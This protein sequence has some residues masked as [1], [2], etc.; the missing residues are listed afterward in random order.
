M[1]YAGHTVTFRGRSAGGARAS[2]LLQAD[3][4]GHWTLLVASPVRGAGY[5]LR[6]N[7]PV[8]GM[9]SAPSG[10]MR[11]RASLRRASRTLAVSPVVSLDITQ[12]Q[13]QLVSSFAL[14]PLLGHGRMVLIRYLRLGANAADDS[15]FAAGAATNA[16]NGI[17]T[18]AV[19]CADAQ[20]AA[21]TLARAYVYAPVTVDN[22]P[23]CKQVMNAQFDGVAGSAGG[24]ER[25]YLPSGRP[26]ASETNAAFTLQ[27]FNLEPDR[28]ANAVVKGWMNVPYMTVLT[29]EI[30]GNDDLD[31][32]AASNIIDSP[33]P[34]TASVD[35]VIQSFEPWCPACISSEAE[36]HL[37]EWADA[38]PALRIVAFACDGNSTQASDWGYEHGWRF[39]VILYNGQLSIGDCFDK[40]DKPLGITWNS[41]TVFYESGYGSEEDDACEFPDVPTYGGYTGCNP[42][43]WSQ[44]APDES[45]TYLED[46]YNEWWNEGGR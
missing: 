21:F 40:V 10:A 42:G 35:E 37:Q 24:P 39:P 3:T 36:Y 17:D 5:H 11:I 18:V 43:T 13:P 45:A 7:V 23:G 20:T 8:T 12:P 4:A 30:Q 25:L 16:S 34:V 31:V 1:A 19:I 15:E 6:W 33:T 14:A 2:V 46:L 44:S 28:A 22:D 9:P 26:V 27:A 29:G 41:D 32:P 38:H